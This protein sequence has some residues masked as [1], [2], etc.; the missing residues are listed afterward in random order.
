ME[1]LRSINY[2]GPFDKEA[3]DKQTPL[4]LKSKIQNQKLRSTCRGTIVGLNF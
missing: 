3:H 2:K 4:N 1:S